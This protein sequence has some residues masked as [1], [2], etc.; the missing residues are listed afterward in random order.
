MDMDG[1]FPRG[2]RMETQTVKELYLKAKRY[3]IKGRSKMKKADL[4][5]AIRLKQKEFGDRISGKSSSSSSSS[6]KKSKS[7]SKGSPKA[8]SAA[9]GTPRAPKSAKSSKAA[10][11]AK[12]PVR[13]PKGTPRPRKSSKPKN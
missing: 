13:T 6:P 11:P 4:V 10:K 3:E 5:E 1:G 7:A 2:Q 8:K 12:G 9:K